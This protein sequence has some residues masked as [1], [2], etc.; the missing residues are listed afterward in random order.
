MLAGFLHFFFPWLW[1]KTNK[2]YF[3]GCL[4]MVFFLVGFGFWPEV[5]AP[6][7]YSLSP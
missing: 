2:Y 6:G 1:L 5:A 4:D 3:L 7:V